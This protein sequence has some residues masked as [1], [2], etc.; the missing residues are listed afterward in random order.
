MDIIKIFI[1]AIVILLFYLKQNKHL[2][3]TYNRINI[4]LLFLIMAMEGI[5]FY[6]N[7]YFYYQLL[8]LNEYFK[9]YYLITEN[10]ILKQRIKLNN[11]YN[12]LQIF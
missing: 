8:I 12:K 7:F 10:F 4:F 1:G 9:Y 5:I 6:I 2:L 11:Y 3:N